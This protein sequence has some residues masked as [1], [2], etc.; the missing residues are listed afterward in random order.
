ME[1]K[2]GHFL[3]LKR[4]GVHFNE[5]LARSSALKNPS[6]L[7]KLMAS[8]GVDERDQYSTTLSKHIWDPTGFPTWAFKEELVKSQQDLTKRN[9]EEKS[10]ILRDSLDF[11]SA[12][13]SEH[14]SRGGTP[15]PA[16]VVR[17]SRGSAA[18]RVMAGLDRESTRSP[19]TA[20]MRKGLD[21]RGR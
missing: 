2:L 4:H 19:Q 14:S 18:E 10:R 20:S 8:A 21:R 12:T 6:L 15:G 9:E 5:K 17:G 3:E 1:K 16:A 13:H 11:V 7:Q